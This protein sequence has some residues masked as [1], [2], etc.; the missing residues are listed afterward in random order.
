MEHDLIEGD[1][2]AWRQNILTSLRSSDE[3]CKDRKLYRIRNAIVCGPITS[4]Q[5]AA[6][7]EAIM[8]CSAAVASEIEPEEMT[9]EE[10]KKLTLPK[11]KHSGK[12]FEKVRT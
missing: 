10:L 1:T 6:D 11:G 4:V 3:S 2:S 8:T 5:L 9:L 7:V 12:Q